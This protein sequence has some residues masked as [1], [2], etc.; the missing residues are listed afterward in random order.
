MSLACRNKAILPWIEIRRSISSVELEFIGI[1]L[2][3]GGLW[4]LRF[5]L[6][7][8]DELFSIIH[9]FI[10]VELNTKPKET[11]SNLGLVCTAKNLLGLEM[12][13]LSLWSELGFFL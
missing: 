13:S 3:L 6:F 5:R 4:V 11:L 7:R 12:I 2:L 9:G 8:G 1:W 10:T